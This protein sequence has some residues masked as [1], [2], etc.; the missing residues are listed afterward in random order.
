MLSHI[1]KRSL[2]LLALAITPSAIAHNTPLVDGAV[3]LHTSDRAGL[4][5]ESEHFDIVDGI[6]K[7]CTFETILIKGFVDKVSKISI[8]NQ[9]PQEYFE[10]RYPHR[11]LSH[12][13]I[14]ISD[15]KHASEIRT[16]IL[17]HSAKT[18]QNEAL[19]PAK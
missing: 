8:C 12:L 17:Y 5:L 11:R 16:L 10:K 3:I 15:K 19:I 1:L 18:R 14:E 7:I 2:M 9:T 6:I 13:K 4:H